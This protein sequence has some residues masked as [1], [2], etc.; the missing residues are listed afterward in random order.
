MRSTEGGDQPVLERP[1]AGP[2]P[3]RA[4]VSIVIRSHQQGRFLAEAVGSARAQTR[5]PDE[6][7]VVDDASTDETAD[8]LAALQEREPLIVVRHDLARGPAASFNA[9]VAA[10]A[11]D[12]I[13]AL[14]ADD[15]L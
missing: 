4:Q 8:V 15:A 3:P 6:I 1:G 2:S 14:D 9:G 12:L 10:S 13:L 11:G 7:V 5:P